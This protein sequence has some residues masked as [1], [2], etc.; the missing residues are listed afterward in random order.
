M[1]KRDIPRFDT[2]LLHSNWSNLRRKYLAEN[3]NRHKHIELLVPS[4][5]AFCRI[6]GFVTGFGGDLGWVW[7]Y[8]F[9]SQHWDWDKFRIACCPRGSAG[10]CARDSAICSNNSK[11]HSRGFISSIKMLFCFLYGLRPRLWCLLLV[12]F[13]G[14]VILILMSTDFPCG[15]N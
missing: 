11:I 5:H 13:K 10:M 4:P 12:D 15:A 3:S 14:K 8:G 1:I 9:L 2:V 7:A 6:N